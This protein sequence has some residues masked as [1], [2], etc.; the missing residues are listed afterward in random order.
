MSFL[1]VSL[2]VSSCLACG[3]R[4]NPRWSACLV[5]AKTLATPTPAI[6]SERVEAPVEPTPAPAPSVDAILGMPLTVFATRHLALRI[7]LPDGSTCWFC[8]GAA[9]VTVLRREGVERGLIWT[10]REL[11]DVV[12]AGWTRA[13]IARLIAVKRVF[14]G[15]MIP[16]DPAQTA[17]GT[18]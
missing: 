12:G 14:A 17:K 3:A 11:A 16:R 10:A 6:E 15:A 2:T 7:K 8:S 9:E 1:A 18:P 5:C 4:I 13:T